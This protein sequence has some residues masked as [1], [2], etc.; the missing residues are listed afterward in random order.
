MER[1]S[2]IVTA[3]D[4]GYWPYLSGLLNSIDKRRRATNTAVGILDVGLSSEQLNRLKLYGAVVVAPGW[5]Y[6]I[7]NF[8]K[9]PPSFYRAMTARPHLPSYFPGYDNYAWIDADCW[10]QDWR[11]VRTLISEAQRWGCSLVPEMDRSY[12]V[13]LGSGGPFS[14]WA[15]SCLVECCGEEVAGNL[16]PWPLINSGVFAAAHESP[17]WQAWS[18]RLG[19]VLAR[20]RNAFF[21]AEQTAL[22]VCIRGEGTAAALL[23]ARYNWMCNRAFPLLSTDGKTFL[24]PNPP[25]EALGI[26]HMAAGTRSGIFP[27]YDESGKI[28]H[29]SLAFPMLPQSN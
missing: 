21:F 3:G 27:L 18:N 29:R 28:H 16:A 17:I 9:P 23:P 5:D 11:A 15:H 8:E 7:S 12:G 22:N 20:I 14:D 10:V 25:Y 2:I 24:E 6:D 19:A 1:K 13:F 26:V 4:S